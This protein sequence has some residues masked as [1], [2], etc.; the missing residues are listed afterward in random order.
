MKIHLSLCMFQALHGGRW[1]GITEVHAGIVVRWVHTGQTVLSR[2]RQMR[3]TNASRK[4][5]LLRVEGNGSVCAC[6]CV[7]AAEWSLELV[8]MK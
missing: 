3:T 7:P 8:E 5:S 1:F 6:V 2:T 4:D